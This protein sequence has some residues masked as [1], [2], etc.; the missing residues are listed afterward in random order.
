MTLFHGV[1]DILWVMVI[2]TYYDEVLQATR[3][4]DLTVLQK[5]QDSSA[6]EGAF[7]GISDERLEHG[8]RLFHTIP[9]ALADAWA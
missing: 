3:Y 6:K 2:A 9:I 8:L 1:L 7:L 5:S 4:E